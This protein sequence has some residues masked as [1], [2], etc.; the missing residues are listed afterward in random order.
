ME[1]F[2][3]DEDMPKN[4]CSCKNFF[5]NPAD[6]YSCS[7]IGGGSIY[8]NFTDGNNRHPNCPLKSLDQQDAEIRANERK[9]VI[10]EI[11][12]LLKTLKD[13]YSHLCKTQK[14]ANQETCRYEGVCRVQNELKKLTELKGENK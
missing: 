14:E 12:K 9:K 3:R 2:I 10:D 8:S 4:C 7:E 11:D 1:V 5:M 13:D 6:T